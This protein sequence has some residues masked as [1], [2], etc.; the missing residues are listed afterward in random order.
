MQTNFSLI[1]ALVMLPM[2][3]FVPV[4][5]IQAFPKS[6]TEANLV[7]M[8]MALLIGIASWLAFGYFEAFQI[9]SG[10]VGNVTERLFSPVLLVQLD[11]FLYALV[12]FSGTA[13]AK[14]SWRFFLA[15]VPLWTLLVYAPVANLMWSPNGLLNQAGARDFSGGLVVHLTAGLTSLLLAFR[16]EKPKVTN[17]SDNV[18]LKYF[19]IL[20]IITGWLGFNLAPAGSWQNYGSLIVINTLIAIVA[21]PFGWLLPT[22]IMNHPFDF[23]DLTNGLL[24]GLVTSTAL[25]GYV[26]PLAIGIVTVTSGLLCRFVTTATHQTTKYFDAVDSFA[27]NGIGGVVGTLGLI[28]FTN[29]KV[30]PLGAMGLLTWHFHFMLVELLAIIIVTAITILGSALSLGLTTIGAHVANHHQMVLK[31]GLTK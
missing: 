10:P 3:F 17:G 20:F 27:I 13:I 2:I 24:T 11:F 31:K 7:K 18:V 9:G 15:F 29:Q 30:T 12:M 26:S 19:A 25:V 16:I 14:Y 23:S 6:K 22:I 21:A 5:Y 1:C 8:L 28:V 4:L